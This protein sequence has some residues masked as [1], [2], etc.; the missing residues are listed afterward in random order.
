M[1]S[2]WA[3]RTLPALVL[4]MLVAG[5]ALAGGAGAAPARHAAATS[6]AAG[7]VETRLV[8]HSFNAIGTRIVGHGTVTSTLRNAA[9]GTVSTAQKAVKVT[10]QGQVGPGPCQILYLQI[11]E[12]DL[13]LLGLHVHLYSATAGQ[14]IELTLSADSS[15]GVLGKLFCDLTN[16]S[17]TT[18]GAAATAAKT[19]TKRLH[20]TTVLQ[21][22]ASVFE[23]GQTT[24]QPAGIRSAQAPAPKAN[25]PVL[26]LILGPL[27][28]DLLGLIV[29]LNK[30]AL[31]LDAVP[32]TTLGNLFCSLDGVGGT[33][34]SLTPITPSTTGTTT[35]P[36][37][38]TP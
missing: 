1:S 29:D 36:A 17:I 25:C 4:C 18:P 22:Q 16:A 20:S 19:L 34:P 3:L 32:G 31:D 5:A 26:H 27:H 11:D 8:L 38:A 9:G 15:H 35:A 23:P 30:V 37:P 14:P 21:A 7:T 6:Q 28:L 13:T 10:L 24:R 33:A 12:L 2:S